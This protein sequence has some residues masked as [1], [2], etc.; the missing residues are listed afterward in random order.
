MSLDG[1]RS[2]FRFEGA[3]RQAILQFKYRN[4]KAL[5]EPLARAMGD[6]LREHPLPADVIVPTPLHTRRL[7]ERG[8]NQSALLARELARLSHLPVVEGC[9]V[10]IKNTPPQTRTKSAVERHHNIAGAFAC[11]NRRLEGK[12]ILLI[13]DVCTSGATLNSCAFALKAGGATSVW[14]LTLA[15]ETW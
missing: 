4:L 11:R 6:Y 9:L 2:V 15:R 3:V 12:R 1:V 10:R 7:R 5:A 14:G 13:D 8:Y